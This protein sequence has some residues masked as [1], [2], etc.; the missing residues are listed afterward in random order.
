MSRWRDDQHVHVRSPSV[1]VIPPPV[2]HT[3]RGM[4]QVP[5]QI[6]DVFATPRRDFSEK[7]GWVLKADESP[8]H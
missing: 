2:V 1:T 8:M 3:T 7:D 4:D 6:V 5:N